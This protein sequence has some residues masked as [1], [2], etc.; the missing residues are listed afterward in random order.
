MRQS[1]SRRAS[2]DGRRQETILRISPASW[3]TPRAAS[4]SPVRRPLCPARTRAQGGV[5]DPVTEAD[6]GA[7]RAMRA[8][9]EAR[10]PDH[11]IAGEEFGGAAGRG[12]LCL[13]PRPDRRHPRLHLRPAELDDPDRLARGGRAGGR[14]DRRAARSTS[15]M[16]AS[17]TAAWLVAPGGQRRSRRAAARRWPRRGCRRPIP[18][19]SHGAEADGFERLRAAVAADPLRPGRLCLCPARRRQRST[20]SPNRA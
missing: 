13:E 8:L 14:P 16:S 10:F 11:G 15:A 2:D 17:A 9:I 6:R 7:E 5:F 19:S 4:P 18:I 20:W 12:A 1:G 3:R